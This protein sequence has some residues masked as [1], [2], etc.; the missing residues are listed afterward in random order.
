[1]VVM[2]FTSPLNVIIYDQFD[3][4]ETTDKWRC[5][6]RINLFDVQET[7]F[8]FSGVSGCFSERHVTHCI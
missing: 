7:L 3:V 1:M 5:E 6:E 2:N 4:Q 8:S